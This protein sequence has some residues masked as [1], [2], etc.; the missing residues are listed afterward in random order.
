MF[1]SKQIDIFTILALCVAL[2]LTQNPKKISW[3][4]TYS[5]AYTYTYYDDTVHSPGVLWYNWNIKS[6]QYDFSNSLGYP[7]C[8]NLIHDNEECTLLFRN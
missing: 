8:H 7:L 6:M 3:P 2:T 1:I 4:N 5:Q